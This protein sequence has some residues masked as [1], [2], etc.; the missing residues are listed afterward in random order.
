M[1]EGLDVIDW[2]SVSLAEDS[3]G[4][5]PELI[6]GL[7]SRDRDER[8]EARYS[9][10]YR[11]FWRVVEAT[12]VAVPFALGRYGLPAKRKEWARLLGIE[13]P[14]LTDAAIESIIERL[15]RVQWFP[16]IDLFLEQLT[17]GQELRLRDS[18]IRR[19][20]LR[21]VGTRAFLPHVAR[22]TD[23]ED[24]DICG[25]PLTDDD[26]VHLMPLTRLRKLQMPGSSITDHGR[27]C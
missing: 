18:R 3:A 7:V 12:P 19:L 22:H 23:L 2:D 27:R 5:L 17:Q 8:G 24:L 4:E 11:A 20:N 14:P 21:Q 25:I 15:A 1:L 26:L 16:S 10:W 9:L 6:R 13:D